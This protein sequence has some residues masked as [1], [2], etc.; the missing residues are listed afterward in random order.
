MNLRQDSIGHDTQTLARLAPAAPAEQGEQGQ[1]DDYE[2]CQRRCRYVSA[3]YA[4]RLIRV[5]VPRAIGDV[6]DSA[7][8]PSG[9]WLTQ[10]A[11]CIRACRRVGRGRIGAAPQIGAAIVRAPVS[12]Y[13]GKQGQSGSRPLALGPDWAWLARH[14]ANGGFAVV[15][16]FLTLAV[17]DAARALA[18]LGKFGALLARTSRNSVGVW[19]VG[20]DSTRNRQASATPCH[21]RRHA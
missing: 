21:T 15:V 11:I 6:A 10:H 7:V 2:G 18:R 5:K 1:G 19:L 12:R 3:F 14:I 9:P 8:R 17:F 4:R 20:V 13:Q 16:R